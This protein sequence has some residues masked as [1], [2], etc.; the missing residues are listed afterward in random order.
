M[1]VQPEVAAMGVAFAVRQ[2][3]RFGSAEDAWFW[4]MAALRGRRDGTGG[5]GQGYVRPC[6]PDDIMLC[7]DRL[8][9]SRRIDSSH[10]TVLRVWGERQFTPGAGGAAATDCRLWSE[11]MAYLARALR[12]KAIVE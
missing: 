4:T 6:D 5:G 3:Q 10:A 2:T 12:A 8:Y 1:Q 11:A 7:L 9:R